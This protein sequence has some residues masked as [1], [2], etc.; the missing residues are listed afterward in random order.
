MV[1]T[2]VEKIHKFE[3][4]GLGKAPFRF[5]GQETIVYVACPG[6]P[7]QPGGYCDYCGQAIKNAF[8]IQASDG[9]RFKVGCECI[10]KTGDAGLIRVVK[11]EE[12]AKRRAKADA[13]REK[14][15]KRERD[16]IAAFRAGRC[17]SLR[18]Q[19]HPKGREGSAHD[20][21]EWCLDNHCYGE[22]VL[23]IIE[24]SMA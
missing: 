24:D 15:W 20:Y 19:P 14:K 21:V 2:M 8:H 23:A 11:E 18:S 17:E 7:E 5:I 9:K 3:A 10:R 1:A 6:A 12:A 22:A 16:L 4:A 13:R